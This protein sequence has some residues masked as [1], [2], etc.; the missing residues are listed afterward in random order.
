MLVALNPRLA[1]FSWCSMTCHRCT[2]FMSAFL[3]AFL[4]VGPA[5][6]CVTVTDVVDRIEGEVPGTTPAVVEGPVAD[7]ITA[8]ISSVTGNVVPRGGS[9]VLADLPDGASTYVVRIAS[10]C[11]THHGRFSRQLVRT[12]IEGL[13][14][15]NHDHD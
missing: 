12:W 4:M 1:I 6:A 13:A 8:G 2:L 3:L 15:K 5:S 9:Y 14:A 7:R 11:A 10:G